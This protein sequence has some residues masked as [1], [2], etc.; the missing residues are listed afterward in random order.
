MTASWHDRIT[1]HPA[2]ALFPM[3]PESELRTL[4][5][6]IK[7]NGL[8][9]KLVFRSEHRRIAA[10]AVEKEQHQ[11]GSKLDVIR[12]MRAGK[13]PLLD[14]RNRLA[15]ME[16]VGILDDGAFENM[17]RGAEICWGEDDAEEFVV[18]ANVRRR[19]LTAEQKRDLIGK[20]VKAKPERSD[21]AT[22]KMIG[23]S[24][25]TVT[26][27][28]RDLEATSEIPK[29]DK[30]VGADGKARPSAKPKPQGKEAQLRA[31]REQQAAP[32]AAE[33]E[34]QPGGVVAAATQRSTVE[35]IEKDIIGWLVW[36]KKDIEALP[37]EKR[38]VLARDCL[39]ALGVNAIDLIVTTTTTALPMPPVLAAPPPPAP[40]PETEGPSPGFVRLLDAHQATPQTAR[41][42]LRD[43]VMRAAVL[44]G[45]CPDSVAD[46][47]EQWRV[48]AFADQKTFRQFLLGQR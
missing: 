3:M 26:S 7:K 46:F 41:A 17:L 44:G 23:A 31:M 1:I 29:L 37:V 24:G 22:A 32:A 8:H 6:D 12:Q 15:A 14:G 35:T 2:A 45:P 28:R 30:T 16:I 13:L 5:E 36:A 27:V 20:L 10:T 38:C 18:S 48:A 43:W 33:R 39:R 21:N 47:N 4:G 42:A 19:H 9:Q 34:A 40:E 25:K 11:A